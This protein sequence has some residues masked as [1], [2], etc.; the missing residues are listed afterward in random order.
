[1]IVTSTGIVVFPHDAI[2]PVLSDGVGWISLPTVME[3]SLVRSI[4]NSQSVYL[5]IKSSRPRADYYDIKEKLADDVRR[6]ATP[7][8]P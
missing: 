4:P 2:Y 7:S 5:F 3:H 8:S 1:M 6:K